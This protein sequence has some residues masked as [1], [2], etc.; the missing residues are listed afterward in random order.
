MRYVFSSTEGLGSD[1]WTC[2]YSPLPASPQPAN[3]T[4]SHD[5][6]HDHTLRCSIHFTMLYF[7]HLK[8]GNIIKTCLLILVK[9]LLQ[10]HQV[11][12]GLPFCSGM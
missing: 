4:Q 8:H 11:L 3:R 10:V 1:L 9:T 6:S 2:S 5:Q 12:S 7:K